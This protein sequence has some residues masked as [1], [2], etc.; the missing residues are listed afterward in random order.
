MCNNEPLG[1]TLYQY[2]NDR[3]THLLSRKPDGASNP[4][5]MSET[6]IEKTNVNALR[7]EYLIVN[8]ISSQ[9]PDLAKKIS[10]CQL[11]SEYITAARRGRW[12]DR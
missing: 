5:L 12:D 6:Y 8:A 11:E 1:K 7:E 2:D 4:N 3:A 9:S 10:L